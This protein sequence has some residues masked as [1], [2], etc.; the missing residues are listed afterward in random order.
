[1]TQTIGDY[2][3]A[4]TDAYKH[5]WLPISKALPKDIH[6]IYLS[7]DGVYNKLNIA[8][9]LN[10]ETGKY[11]FENQNIIQVLSTREVIERKEQE[12]ENTETYAALFGY[13]KYDLDAKKHEVLAT[14]YS[15][16]RDIIPS[17]NLRDSLRGGQWTQLE[18]TKV[19]VETINKI[20]HN[21]GWKPDEYLGDQAL[22]EAVKSVESPRILH[23]AT[24]GFFL[25]SEQIAKNYELGRFQQKA[26]GSNVYQ[27]YT[28]PMLRSGLLFA[29]ANQGINNADKPSKTDNGILTAK[30]AMQLNLEGT[31]L[32]VLSA[33]ETAKGD[34]RNGEGVF[35]L[36]RAFRV[37]GA[38]YLIISLW[39]VDDRATKEMMLLF[40][41][42]LIKK[43]MSV[44]ESYNY[45][46]S[47]MRKKYQHPYYWSAFVLIG[48]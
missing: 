28:D 16:R 15:R 7:V 25:A 32:V 33:C 20:M 8:T 46:I 27:A 14:R 9:L 13:P 44:R 2:Q 34:I 17:D 45:A 5:L 22:E 11:L 37:A 31:E 12:K 40:Y 39:R 41:T 43:G 4:L 3:T 24:H 21:N 6:T 23:I 1:L 38:R 47:Q 30:E 18:G 48:M 35:G 10:P 36:Q 42:Q 19:E 26:F 29:G